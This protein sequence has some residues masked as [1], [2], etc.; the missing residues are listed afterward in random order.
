MCKIFATLLITLPVVAATGTIIC[1]NEIVDFN[2]IDTS[3]S[4]PTF[5]DLMPKVDLKDFPTCALNIEATIKSTPSN[6]D[7][8]TAKCVKFFLDDVEV[9]K[10]K[11]APFTLY[12]DKT[13]GEIYSRKPP[14]G[15][16]KLKACTYSD[17]ACTKNESGCKEM[18]VEFLDCNRTTAASNPIGGGYNS[19]AFAARIPTISDKTIK[20]MYKSCDL[21]ND[22]LTFLAHHIAN[23]TIEGNSWYFDQPTM[24]YPKPIDDGTGKLVNSAAAPDGSTSTKLVSESNFGTNNQVEGVEEGDLVQSN[25]DQ[26]FVVYG[27]EIVVL[28]ADNVTITRRTEIPHK[29]EEC[30]IGYVA[31]MLLIDDRLVVVAT[32]YCNTQGIWYYGQDSCDVYIYNTSNMSLLETLNLSGSYLSARAIG[33][34]VHIITSTYVDS[35]VLTQYLEPW[36][37]DI[38]GVNL[39]KAQYRAKAQEQV[40]EHVQEFVNTVTQELDC[41][42]L[43]KL[44]L[45]QNSKDELIFS[46]NLDS[47]VTVT[48]FT[49]SKS[50]STSVT[51][52]MV[53][54][55]GYTVYASAEYIVLAVQ[56]WWINQAVSEQTYLIS[57][58]LEGPFSNVTSLGTVPGYILNQ[59]SIDHAVQDGENYL[60]VASTT[61]AQW[62]EVDGKWI[63][64]V[65]S[66]SQVTVLKMDDDVSSM[67]VVGLV[68][69]LG[70]D[71]ETIYSV[72]FMGDRGYVT[73]FKRTDPFYTLDLSDPSNPMKVGELEIPGYSSYLH[74][75]GNDLILG[76][77]QGAD[78]EGTLLG[79]QISLFDVSDF[80][81]PVQI[82]SFLD[83]GNTNVSS[84]SSSEAEYDFK[85]F[86]YLKDSQLLIIPLTIYNYVPCTYAFDY[87]AVNDTITSVPSETEGK[88]GSTVQPETS[89]SRMFITP[90]LQPC[91][92]GTNGFDGFRVYEVTTEGISSYLSV[93]HDIADW[94]QKSC[95]SSAYLPT[96]SFVFDGDLMTLKSHTILSH[97][98][99]TLMEDAKPI[100][101]DDQNTVCEPYI[102]F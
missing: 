56:G 2:V 37:E 74:P 64:N 59:F 94:T 8:Q 14:R 1:S 34:N 6:C 54:S 48:S 51:S 46:N 33:D 82:Q 12:G 27:T 63:Q 24:Y 100:N 53:P 28:A 21:L 90:I 97:D 4:P 42:S 78:S 93:K 67:S 52:M 75:I 71:G 20:Q 72:R 69:N 92:E 29:S 47:I 60:R 16:H 101:L 49:T 96:R 62:A 31:S 83:V 81:N 39:T 50:N 13:G 3:V 66:T 76:V 70:K 61:S 9:R 79:V 98:L 95:W 44:A 5:T 99:S 30:T 86:R 35:Y 88:T 19:M 18:E 87:A 15:I 26:V 45:F 22:D 23:R 7:E 102:L 41:T 58:K 36:R 55:G 68:D 85:A 40:K 65:S 89:D 38:Y 11:F 73:T 25:G 91:F 17:K 84:T 77:G 43:Q 32:S 57:Y 10:E 80:S